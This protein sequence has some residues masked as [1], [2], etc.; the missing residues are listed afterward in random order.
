MSGVC[1]VGL[2]NVKSLRGFVLVPLIVYCGLGILFLFAGFVS[3]FR[4]R[5]VMK[6]DGTKTDKL[7]KLITRIFIFSVLYIVPALIV[8]G[9][10]IYEQSYFDNW[11]LT[12]HMDM[13]AKPAYS[14][15]CPVGARK[16]NVGHRPLFFIFMIKYLMSMI[17][18]FTSSIW[19]CS[20]KTLSS[21]RKFLNNIKRQRSE[22]YV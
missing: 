18:G 10:L 7:E 5:T 9:C 3:L 12:W 8:I 17:V 6:L 21:W 16:L 20:N 14:I 15:A 22:A 4:I 11:M 1:Y 2:W 13:C 19:V